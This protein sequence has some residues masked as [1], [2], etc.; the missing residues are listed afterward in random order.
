MTDPIVYLSAPTPWGELFLAASRQGLCRIAWYISEVAFSA[1]IADRRRCPVR[2]VEHGECEVLEESCRQLAEYLA[3]Q[4]TQFDLPLDLGDRRP[5]QQAVYGALLK[6]PY[7]EVVSY[8]ELAT[9]AGY[10]GA[11]RAAGSAMRENPLAI[12]I[13]CHRVVLGSGALGG[14]GGRPDLKR[15]LLAIEGW[16]KR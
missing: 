8:G 11:A 14:F 6:V 7:G 16:G 3:G 15:Q 13:P 10:P 5:F 9:L 1:E 12:V 2:R 4:R